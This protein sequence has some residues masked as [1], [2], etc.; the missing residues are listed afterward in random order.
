MVDGSIYVVEIL[1]T[2]AAKATHRS[3]DFCPKAVHNR[4]QLKASSPEGQAAP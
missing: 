4:L 3:L 2:T 1:R